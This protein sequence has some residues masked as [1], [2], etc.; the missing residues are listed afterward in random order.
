MF[1]HNKVV[2]ALERKRERFRQFARSQ[3]AEQRSFG[4]VFEQFGRQSSQSILDQL[5]ELGE[6]WPGALPTAEMDAAD[7]LCLPFAQRWQNHQEA[8]A[9]ALATLYNRP[10]LAVDGSQ[11]T[12]TKDLVP[13]VGAVQIGWFINPHRE[14]GGANGTRP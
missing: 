10:V 9:W 12:P 6:P 2:T 14:A 8:R 5:Q 4:R 1:D 7:G 13:P 3:A 11:I